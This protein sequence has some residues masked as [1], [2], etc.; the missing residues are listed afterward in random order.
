MGEAGPT[1]WRKVLCCFCVLLIIAGIAVG[2]GLGLSRKSNNNDNNNVAGPPLLGDHLLS[3]A[4]QQ[5]LNE[6]LPVPAGNQTVA[7]ASISISAKKWPDSNIPYQ[8]HNALPNNLRENARI[9]MQRIMEATCIK[10]I[11]RTSEAQ[12]NFIY[13]QPYQTDPRGG[14]CQS[15]VGVNGAS[16]NAIDMS[17]ACDP[18][19]CI[20]E[21]LHALGFNHEHVR[22][23]RGR[24]VT[25][26][27]ENIEPSYNPA[28]VARTNFAIV[29]D[30]TT[31]TEYDLLSIMHYPLDGFAIPGR[32]VLRLVNQN[33][34]GRDQVGQLKV[35]SEGDKAAL[36]SLYCRGRQPT[37]APT[38]SPTPP[39]ARTTNYVY[40]PCRN[41]TQC[42]KNG[43][44]C[45]NGYC[46]ITGRNPCTTHNDCY[47]GQYC[48]IGGECAVCIG[49]RQCSAST[50]FD[51]RCDACST[52]CVNVNSP[53]MPRNTG[54]YKLA[55]AYASADRNFRPW[56]RAN[57]FG[58]TL[59]L[60][61]WNN[62]WVISYSTPA[63]GVLPDATHYAMSDV[64]LPTSV[65]VWNRAVH[66]RWEEDR[67]V[68]VTA[69]A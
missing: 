20:H 7:A 35:L 42:P 15:I 40:I 31:D 49:A 19:R 32:Q 62:L 1:N 53:S 50:S 44:T 17:N 9:A 21:I 16:Y 58:N 24:Y 37:Q 25:F 8:F 54:V 18:G 41:N 5:I 60:F 68:T 55:G 4:Q 11:Q 46:N 22:A 57:L 64:L 36:N 33:F 48:G 6:S 67:T 69:I 14:A 66:P 47:F 23:D 51:T 12:R 43:G 28:V 61:S 52:I 29:T 34:P 3:E 13:F 63:Q 26:H 59:N 30:T 27:P 65:P 45:A 38:P 56:Y 39:D 10:F 2:L